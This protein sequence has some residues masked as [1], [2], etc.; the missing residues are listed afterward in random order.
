M[1]EGA[2]YVLTCVQFDAGTQTCTQTAWMPPPTVL[3]PLSAEAGQT[4]G[5]GIF[6][7]LVAIW[8][9]KLPRRGL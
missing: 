4:L 8:I 1:P 5:S 2:G 9:S 7:G 6:A 3:P